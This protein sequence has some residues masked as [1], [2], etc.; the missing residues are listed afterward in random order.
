MNPVKI[1]TM[2]RTARE[3]GIQRERERELREERERAETERGE[4]ERGGR[5]L[6]K[7][8]YGERK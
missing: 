2:N 6:V 1:Y 4:T 5:N 3:R 8:M 7:E